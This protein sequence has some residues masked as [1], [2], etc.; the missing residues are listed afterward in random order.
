M[1][2][3][4]FQIADDCGAL[5]DAHASLQWYGGDVASITLESQGG[6]RNKDYIKAHNL[7][8]RRLASLFATLVDAIVV[9]SDTKNLDEADRRF[10]M[11]GKSYPQSL[12]PEL[13][14]VEIARMLRR[15]AAEVGRRE[16]ATGPGN[17]AKRIEIRFAIDGLALRPPI[18][19]KEIL[20]KPSGALDVEA[21]LQASRP[22][23]KPLRPTYMQDAVARRAVEVRA[24]EVAIEELSKTWEHVV[25]V[26]A[27]ESFDL[28]C[29]SAAEELHVEV[30]GTT[31]DGATIVLTRNE[32][33]HAQ[34]QHPRVALYVVSRIELSLKDG[35]PVASGG[36]L[37]RYE[38]WA[39]ED[40]ELIPLSFQCL[41][42][43]SRG[44]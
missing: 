39:I 33:I 37:A 7:I 40:F 14:A 12:T 8:V 34:N 41:M 4:V 42:L 3:E 5:I 18:W 28:L 15:G 1:L 11:G 9:S 6:G 10:L 43:S 44:S 2:T 25:D 36:Q 16:G 38:P 30:K 22:P 24:M 23:L 20:I 35:A 26:S 32:V 21:V 31:S 27:V 29:R 13:D 19:L 17:R